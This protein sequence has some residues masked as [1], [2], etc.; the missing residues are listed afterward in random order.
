MTTKQAYEQVEVTTRDLIREAVDWP[1]KKEIA[2]EY[3]IPER[4]IRT[5]VDRG[6]VESI[7]LNTIRVN[8]AS[9]EAYI[10]STHNLP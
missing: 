7:R 3:G 9:L 4:Y 2:E 6:L 1:N 10:E 8:P 5:L